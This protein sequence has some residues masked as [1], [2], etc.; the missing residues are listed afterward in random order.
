L[1]AFSLADTLTSPWELL[2]G[3]QAPKKGSE[4]MTIARGNHE[5]CVKEMIRLEAIYGKEF[6]IIR[7]DDMNGTCELQVSEKFARCFKQV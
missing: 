3:K 6:W 1:Q 2:P 5:Y 7:L 4:E